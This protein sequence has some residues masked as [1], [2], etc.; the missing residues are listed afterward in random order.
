MSRRGAILILVSVLAGA[1]Y[2]SFV[3]DWVLRGFEGMSEVVSQLAAPGAPHAT[4]SRMMDLL[5]AALVLVL[6]P[7]VGAAMP[8]RPM[9][10]V[11]LISTL[12]FAVGA[13]AAAVVTAPCSEGTACDSAADRSQSVLHN[14]LSTA[15]D[16]G[17]YIGMAAAWAATRRSGPGWFHRCAWWLFWGSGLVAGAL[18]GLSVV[19]DW[20][21]WALATSQ[22]LHIAGMSAWLVCLGMFASVQPDRASRA[23]GSP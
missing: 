10:T 1:A 4:L 3:L 15:S 23:G 5:C 22:R 21:E 17:L 13:A 19:A 11:V 6:L 16:V 20:P 8:P 14:A 18:M 7:Y 12:V 9:R 2:S